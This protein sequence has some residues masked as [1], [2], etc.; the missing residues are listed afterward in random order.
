MIAS[1]SRS[2]APCADISSNRVADNDVNISS[3]N[4][5]S[6]IIDSPKALK[7]EDMSSDNYILPLFEVGYLIVDNEELIVEVDKFLSVE[8]RLKLSSIFYFDDN[9]TKREFFTFTVNFSQNLV[10]RYGIELGTCE[11]KPPGSSVVEVENDICR[12]GESTKRQLHRRIMQA[13][14]E[15]ETPRHF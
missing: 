6:F 1:R 15:K 10:D 4:E 13:K 14:S 11:F 8:E 3:S 7:E 12:I 2:R 5:S 9:I